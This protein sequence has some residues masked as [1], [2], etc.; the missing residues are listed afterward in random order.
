MCL[1]DKMGCGD[2]GHFLINEKTGAVS[3]FGYPQAAIWDLLTRGYFYDRTVRM[4]TA[5]TSLQADEVETLIAESLETW[6]KAGF[7]VRGNL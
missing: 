5:I 6:A 7:L 2:E 3:S 1:F 4:L